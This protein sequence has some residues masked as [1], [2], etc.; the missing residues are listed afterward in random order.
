MKPEIFHNHRGV[1]LIAVLFMLITIIGTILICAFPLVKEADD[2]IRHRITMQRI[3]EIKRAMLGRIAEKEGG[4]N[5]NVF[6][7]A[8]GGFLSDFGMASDGRSGFPDPFGTRNF[9]DVLLRGKE[10]TDPQ[11]IG[12]EKWH[13]DPDKKYWAGYRGERYLVP[14]SYDSYGNPQF[15][16]GWGNPFKV[17]LSG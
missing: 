14:N 11:G 1:V 7:S 6:G 16:D 17:I 4:E 10:I 2:E 8:C 12:W 3:K 5:I 15:V 9:L 13:Y